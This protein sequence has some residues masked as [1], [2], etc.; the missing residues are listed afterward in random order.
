ME[1]HPFMITYTLDTC[2]ENGFF[3][4]NR[5]FTVRN[6]AG[7]CEILQKPYYSNMNHKDVITTKYKSSLADN[8][9]GFT[10]IITKYVAGY[11]GDMD[12]SCITHG[13]VIHHLSSSDVIE[14]ETGYI[15]VFHY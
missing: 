11:M 3:C 5:T 1:S 13:G 8:M 4:L 15:R 9:L 12:I 14:T 2:D 7:E 6:Q 10:E